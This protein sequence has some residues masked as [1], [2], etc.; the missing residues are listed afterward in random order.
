MGELGRLGEWAA[1]VKAELNDGESAFTKP[2]GE[3]MGQERV[4]RGR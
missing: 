4:P 2:C 1:H 3:H